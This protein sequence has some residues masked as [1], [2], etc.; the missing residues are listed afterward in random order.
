MLR[1]SI[2]PFGDILDN[3]YYDYGNLGKM[4]IMNYL[5]NFIFYLLKIKTFN[6]TC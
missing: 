1:V 6:E 5:L 2:W 3:G 4:L